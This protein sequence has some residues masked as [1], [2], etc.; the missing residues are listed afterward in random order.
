M[1]DDVDVVLVVRDDDVVLVVLDDDVVDGVL[2]VLDDDVVDFDVV[3]VEGL[4]VVVVVWVDVVV[5]V[6]GVCKNIILETVN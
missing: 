4:L 5:A 1:L 2:V 6:G 3:V